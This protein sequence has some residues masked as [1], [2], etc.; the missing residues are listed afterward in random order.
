[1]GQLLG[2]DIEVTE[3]LKFYNFSIRSLLNIC[4]SKELDYI[5]VLKHI[6]NLVRKCVHWL[7]PCIGCTGTV[8]PFSYDLLDEA[9]PVEPA[10]G[11]QGGQ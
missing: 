8:V 4:L 5:E 10:K 9:C 7:T 6:A 11:F 2:G 3:L 1:M